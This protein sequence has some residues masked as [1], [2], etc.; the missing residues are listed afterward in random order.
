MKI[1]L[2][3]TKA[4]NYKTIITVNL[5]LLIFRSLSAQSDSEMRSY[6]K[7]VPVGKETS[8]E[9][10]NKYGTIQITPWNKDSA[11]IRAEVKA[12]APNQSKLKKM[13]DGITVNITETK[14]LVRA[15]TDFTQNINMLF[16]SFKGMTSK[17]I[18]YDSR[19]EINYYISIPEY[20]NLKI[21]NKYG[22]V[23]MEDNTGDFSISVSNGSFKANSIGKGSS[24]TLAFCD[25]TINSMTSGN[26]DA[27]FSEISIGETGDISINSISSRYDI[28]KAGMIRFESRRD[29]FFIDNIETLHGNSY[30]TDYKISNLKKE[31]DLTTRYGSVNAD[32]IEKGFEAININSGYSDISLEFDQGSSYNLDIRHINAF[33]VLPD[34]NVNT[35]QK[36]LNE[37]KKEYMT[38]GTVGRNP[39]STKVKIDATRGNIYLK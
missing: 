11:Y 25:A 36:A 38:Y 9:V 15:Q 1:I 6:I 20:L 24:I 28:K 5:I 37:E 13:F 39:G 8:L 12:F 16:E 31:L 18:S 26:I 7:T 3:K 2:K 21:E 4:M 30:F 17:L 34:Q 27:S 19:V 23:Y 29:K 35:E 22:D 10:F 33:L 32:L 14:Y